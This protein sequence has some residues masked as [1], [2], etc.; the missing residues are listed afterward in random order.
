[1][2][3]ELLEEALPQDL[4]LTLLEAIY[5]LPLHRLYLPLSKLEVRALQHNRQLGCLRRLCR[6][7]LP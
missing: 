4:E 2:S 5:L 6:R 1:M 3:V 7:R